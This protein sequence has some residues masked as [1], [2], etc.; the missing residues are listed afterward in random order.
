VPHQDLVF[1][2][3]VF[4]KP[5]CVDEWHK[6]VTDIIEEM[7]K[8]AAF[9]SCYLHQNANDVNH[10][11]LYER[12]AEPSVE[13]FLQNQAKPYRLE[14]EAKLEWLLQRPREPQIL[15]PL[16]QWLK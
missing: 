5:G 1:Y 9:V 2:V 14:Y 4:V 13:A 10:F 3:N 15:K 6:A 8:E 16:G 7:S 11:T 12:W